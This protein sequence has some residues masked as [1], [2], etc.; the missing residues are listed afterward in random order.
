MT[1]PEKSEVDKGNQG[2]GTEKPKLYVIVVSGREKTVS[3]HK[4]TYTQVVQLFLNGANLDPN[5]IYTVTYRKGNNENHEGSMVEGDVVT[6]KEGMIFNVSAT[7][8]S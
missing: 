8:K 5:Y 1:H 4:L 7:T 6:I 3:D 2:N